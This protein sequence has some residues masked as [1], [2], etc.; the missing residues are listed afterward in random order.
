MALY[1]GLQWNAKAGRKRLKGILGMSGYLPNARGVQNVKA[2]GTKAP[3]D[4]SVLLCHGKFDV[5]VDKHQAELTLAEIRKKHTDHVELQY[6]PMGHEACREEVD[7]VTEW[8]RVQF[9]ER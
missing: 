1:A 6:Y 3:E 8:L 4:F 9:P 5:M 2:G 7:A